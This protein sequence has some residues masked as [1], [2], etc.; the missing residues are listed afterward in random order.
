MLSHS[1]VSDSLWPHGH[2]VPL[3]MVILQAKYL[4]GL[5]CLPPGDLPS[6]GIELRYLTLQ[7]NSLP[8]ESPGKPKN[9]GV[10]SLSLL[11]GIFLTQESNWCLLH[12]RW[13]L[14]K[15]RYQESPWSCRTHSFQQFFIFHTFFFPICQRSWKS[16]QW[17]LLPR[18]LSRWH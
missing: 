11:Q 6:P 15:L 17:S 14:Y 4:S 13:I 3:S 2:Q 5:P 12:C 9:T 8:S 16:Q 18:W 10:G 1:V 7:M